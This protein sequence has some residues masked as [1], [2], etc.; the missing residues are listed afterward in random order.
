MISRSMRRAVCG[1]IDCSG[2]IS[3]SRLRPAGVSSN[4]QAKTSA[5]TKPIASTITML[6]GNQAGAPNIG[7]TVPATCTISHAPT[8]YS[9]ASG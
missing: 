8:R 3:S 5:G 7:S 6:R 1:A 2:A 9:P 4:T